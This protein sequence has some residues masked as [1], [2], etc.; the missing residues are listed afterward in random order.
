MIYK[1]SCSSRQITMAD[2]AI[3]QSSKRCHLIICHFRK[4]MLLSR[5]LDDPYKGTTRDYWAESACHLV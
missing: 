2:V 3:L 1:K 5:F 4:V